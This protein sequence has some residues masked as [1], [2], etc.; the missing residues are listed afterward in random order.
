[1]KKI[2]MFGLMMWVMGLAVPAFAVNSIDKAISD[3]K[4]NKSAISISV[5]DIQTGKTVFEL[6]DEKPVNPASTQKLVTSAAAL[7][8]LGKDY[9]FETALYKSTNNELFLKLGADPYLSTGDLKTLF[10]EAKT[11]NVLTPK[12]VYIDDYVLDSVNWG[13]GW[14]WD[15][16][17]N[18]LMP[19]FGSYNLDRNLINIIVAPTGMGAPANVYTEVFYPMGFMNLVTTGKSNKIKI[20]H[21]TN[22]PAG[23]LQLDGTVQKLSKVTI[24]VPNMKLYFRLRL[25]EA[26]NNA[27]IEYYGQFAEKKLPDK[28]VYLI[29][30]VTHPLKIAMADILQ[31]SN[32]MV[33][34]SVFKIAGGKFVKNTGSIES[35]VK[36]FNDFCSKQGLKAEDIKIVDGSGVSKNNL[37]TADFMTS[38]LV[39]EAK[40]EN[41]DVYKSAMASPGSGTLE[42]RMLYFKDNLKAK[43]GTLTDISAIAGYITTRNGRDLAFDIMIN[44]PKSKPADKKMLEEYILRAIFTNY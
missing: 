16:A 13:E 29:K 23:M 5:K 10:N 15:D 39:A 4:I 14:Q 42:N 31:N 32:N 36:M 20:V 19:K 37:M 11:K 43:T 35:A 28:N 7:N 44:D 30:S 17:L 2:L 6:N 27:K 22:L 40:L 21:N 34:E 41:F 18:P 8:T 33:A 24:P 9:K 25:E 3:S 38:F 1:M 26:I 12:M